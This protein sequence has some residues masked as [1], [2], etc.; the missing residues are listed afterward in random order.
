MYRN[1][2]FALVFVVVVLLQVLLLDGL[3]IVP[4]AMPMIFIS[5]L[6]LQPFDRST[7]AMLGLGALLGMTMDMLTGLGGL[8]TI[9][10]LWLAFSRRGVIILTLGK[11]L[12]RENSVPSP[13]TLGPLRF[14]LYGL[15]GLAMHNIVF[16]LF[17]TLSFEHLLH[18]LLRI[19]LSTII[20]AP[21]MW[22][23]V[24][25]FPSLSK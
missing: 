7:L 16:C 18:T 14:W 12:L 5:F 1:F 23:V 22:V 2:E 20:S 17:E 11:D 15:A 21:L 9:A 4:Y 13:R 25:L 19:V 8:Y 6:L 10:S 3:F 24:K